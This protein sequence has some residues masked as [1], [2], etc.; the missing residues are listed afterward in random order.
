MNTWVIINHRSPS[1]LPYHL[2]ASLEQCTSPRSDPT[3]VLAAVP[4]SPI[5]QPMKKDKTSCYFC[6][7]RLKQCI[8]PS[9]KN[10]PS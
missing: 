7:S 4:S 3:W 5:K 1:R 6:E 9:Y 10:P 2:V 8:G